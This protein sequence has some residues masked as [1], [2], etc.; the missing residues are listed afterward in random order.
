MN[1]W[2]YAK[3]THVAKQHGSP[4][5]YIKDIYQDGYKEGEYKGGLIGVV[6]GTVS[7]LIV[8]SGAY[9]LNRFITERRRKKTE[10]D[11]AA[12]A[13]YLS[14]EDTCQEVP[15]TVEPIVSESVTVISEVESTSTTDSPVDE[16]AEINTTLEA[17]PSSSLI[18][19]DG[20]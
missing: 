7:S 12:F 6:V 15:P 14:E 8:A 9:F 13:Q 20:C 11:K 18:D 3:M 4:E 10:A 5:Q 1:D 17:E 19:D 16:T 2:S